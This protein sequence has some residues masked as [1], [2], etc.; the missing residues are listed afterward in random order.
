MKYT[1]IERTDVIELLN[2]RK[3]LDDGVRC[4]KAI[5][6][7]GIKVFPFELDIFPFVVVYLTSTNPLRIQSWSLHTNNGR[8]KER[9]MLICSW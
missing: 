5:F 2:S 3:E 4:S 6:T 8:G 1:C 9:H 7:I